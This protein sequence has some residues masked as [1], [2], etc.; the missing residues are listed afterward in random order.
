MA[1]AT[2]RW[3]VHN[4]FSMAGTGVA[5]R[6][7]WDVT[8]ASNEREA[9]YAGSVARYGERHPRFPDMS[10]KRVGITQQQ[11]TDVYVVEA[12][13]DNLPGRGARPRERQRE[14][15]LLMFWSTSLS[16]TELESDWQG[17]PFV[18]SAGT[19]F[20]I[21]IIG[22]TAQLQL[23]VKRWEPGY[24]PRL[25]LKFINRLNKSSF[26]IAVANNR[27]VTIEERQAK[28]LR[29]MP[30][31]EYSQDEDLIEI[32]YGFEFKEDWRV[33]MLDRGVYQG[34]STDSDSESPQRIRE[35][36]TQTPITTPVHL[37]GTGRPINDDLKRTGDKG[38]T[39]RKTDDDFRRS[40]S[41]N[42]VYMPF[43]VHELA[44][45]GKLAL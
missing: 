36:D 45:F 9:I 34:R 10:V 14:R 38:V 3:S 18:N 23:I 32:E 5:A 37:D 30:T 16:Q 43:R 29:I 25:A 40:P 17:K 33:W 42:A 2:E 12:N 35:K 39:D 4:K 28:V 31:R 19:S 24:D 21:P 11:S 8:G 1:K 13:Y 27:S 44:D 22:T 7:E 20:P 6:R 15:P 41:G 26:N